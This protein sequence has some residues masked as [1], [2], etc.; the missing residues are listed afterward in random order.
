[1]CYSISTSLSAQLKRAIHQGQEKSIAEI[2]ERMTQIQD[3]FYANGYTHPKV[4]IY[5]N[6]NP[7]TPVAAEWGLVPQWATEKEQIQK[8][9]RNTL[10]ARCETIFEKPSFKKAIQLRRCLIYVDGF[11]EYHHKNGKAFPHFISLV[12]QGPMILAGVWSERLNPQDVSKTIASFSIITTKPN[13][14]MQHIHNNPKRNEPRMPVILTKELAE[15]WVDD[16]KPEL[17][18]MEAQQFFIP[19][20]DGRMKAHP[21]GKLTGRGALGNQEKAK[22]SYYYPELD[23]LF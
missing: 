5:T 7:N 16:S 4:V 2:K 22:S 9:K 8:I 10:N 11:Y 17:T 19:L 15:G 20:E 18:K 13:V 3:L 12:E 14:L 6:E 1:M 21:V 23:T